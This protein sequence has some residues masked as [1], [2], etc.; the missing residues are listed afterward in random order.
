M[1]LNIKYA[2][3]VDDN[4]TRNNYWIGK[5]NRDCDWVASFY[6][7]NAHRQPIL[8]YGKEGVGKTFLLHYVGNEL[9]EHY[10]GRVLFV[11]TGVFSE[12]YLR[13]DQNYMHVADF[14]KFYSDPDCLLF[15]DVDKMPDYETQQALLK[16][17]KR[18]EDKNRPTL[19][20]SSKTMGKLKKILSPELYSHI[21]SSEIAF[22][23]PP[24][25]NDRKGFIR[26]FL[27][28]K[29]L[30]LDEK[31]QGEL[32]RMAFSF[33]ELTGILN[34]LHY[35]QKSRTVDPD[36]IQKLIAFYTE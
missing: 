19:L 36:E 11:S 2:T 32:I 28:K 6:Y 17:L 18:R 9:K 29:N 4:I 14:L 25:E 24:E 33:G 3:N 10:T 34:S 7:G 1:E 12:Q 20:T 16:I 13:A 27:E 35:N 26:W 8:I 30:I 15:D 5:Q 31:S 23:T 21:S 22:L